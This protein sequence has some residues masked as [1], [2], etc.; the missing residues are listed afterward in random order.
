MCFF[1]GWVIFHWKYTP[2][3]LYPFICQWTS[4]LLHIL[5]I[6]NGAAMN[7]G[8]HMTFSILV[9]SGYMLSSEIA[10]SHGSFMPSFVRNL[11]TVFYSDRIKLLSHQLCKRVPFS[12]YPLQHL[13]FVDFFDDGH[14]TSVR[15]YLIIVLIYTIFFFKTFFAWKI[16]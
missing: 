3:L 1:N 14:L 15:Q 5:P 9:S 10:G 2:Q 11:H 8:V 12:P 6:V 13:L 7:N 16:L 4:R